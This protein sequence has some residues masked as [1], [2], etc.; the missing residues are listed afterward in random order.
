MGTLEGRTALMTGGGRGIGRGI[1]LELAKDGADIVIADIDLDNAEKT[2]TEIGDLGRKATVIEMNITREASV[3][4]ALS[5]A[6]AE[7]GQINISSSMT[8]TTLVN[9]CSTVAA[10]CTMSQSN[11]AR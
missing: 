8:L 6:I 1:V 7:H 5:T 4:T 9:G 2:A 10:A 3:A 11:L